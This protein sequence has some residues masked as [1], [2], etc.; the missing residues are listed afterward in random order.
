[1]ESGDCGGSVW[2]SS[3]DGAQWGAALNLGAAG[4]IDESVAMNVSG[5]AVVVWQQNYYFNPPTCGGITGS[6]IWVRRLK[7]GTWQA[8]ERVSDASGVDFSFYAINPVVTIDDNGSITVAWSQQR[9]APAPGEIQ[10]TYVR[11]FDSTNWSTAARISS[12]DRYSWEVQAGVAGNGDVTVVWRQDTNPYD[13]SQTAGGPILPT[14]WAARYVAASAGWAA[15]QRIG[16]TDLVGY[17]YEERPRISVGRNGHVGVLWERQKTGTTPERSIYATRFDPASVAWVTPVAI[18]QNPASAYWPTV[19]VDSTGNMQGRLDTNRIKHRQP[20]HRAT[21]RERRDMESA[22]V[23]R[24][25]GYPCAAAIRGNRCQRPGTRGLVANRGNIAK[26][27]GA[28]HNGQRSRDHRRNWFRRGPVAGR[29]RRRLCR[30]GTTQDGLHL[31]GVHDISV[32]DP[33]RPVG[34]R[35]SALKARVSPGFRQYRCSGFP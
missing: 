7:A 6:E 22:A 25:A 5:D 1:V 4:A 23:A 21:R 20:V 3:F 18:E 26:T 2:V 10:G 11:R 34:A 33:L 13:P 24:S 19:A 15:S 29:E 30:G 14:I 35:G 12:P 17:D 16:T 8:A 27:S 32:R 9:N 31:H 28:T